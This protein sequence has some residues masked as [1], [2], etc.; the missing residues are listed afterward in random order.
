MG[1]SAETREK[2]KRIKTPDMPWRG[3]RWR[4]DEEQRGSKKISSVV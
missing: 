3:G 4:R 1:R 2:R